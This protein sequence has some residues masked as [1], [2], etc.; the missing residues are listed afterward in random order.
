MVVGGEVEMH[1]S[2]AETE[3]AAKSSVRFRLLVV[4]H[5]RSLNSGGTT[6]SSGVSLLSRNFI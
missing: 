2:A 1:E 4:A 3:A 5:E 6:A